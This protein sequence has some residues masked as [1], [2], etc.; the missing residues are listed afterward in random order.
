MG[1]G[2][3]VWGGLSRATVVS[4]EIV[5]SRVFAFGGVMVVW[6]RYV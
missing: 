2:L 1:C 5:E 4:Y 3:V 6:Y